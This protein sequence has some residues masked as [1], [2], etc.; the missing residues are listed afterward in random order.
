MKAAKQLFCIKAQL[1]KYGS[2]RQD[3]IFG[4]VSIEGKLLPNRMLG[5]CASAQLDRVAASPFP[6]ARRN[7]AHASMGGRCMCHDHGPCIIK[8]S[9]GVQ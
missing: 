7:S 3:P 6:M 4:R 5:L 1:N 9:T 8:R 2:Y